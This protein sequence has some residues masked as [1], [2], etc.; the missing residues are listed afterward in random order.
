M[1]S[2]YRRTGASATRG[3]VVAVVPYYGYARQDRKVR[4][5]NGRLIAKSMH[6]QKTGMT[7]RVMAR[8]TE[9]TAQRPDN[10]PC[11]QR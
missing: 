9:M 6:G 4:R 2:K 1:R 10:L 5:C 3:Q 11:K 7:G 8:E